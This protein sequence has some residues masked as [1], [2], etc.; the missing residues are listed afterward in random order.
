MAAPGGRTKRFA[1]TAVALAF[2]STAV[3]CATRMPLPEGM[4]RAAGPLGVPFV[5]QR[6]AECGPSS[7]A[8]VLEWS[9]ESVDME[10]LVDETWTPGRGGALAADLMGAARRH[11]RIAVPLRGLEELQRELAAGHPVLVM[12]NLGWGWL[13]FWHF[14]VAIGYDANPPPQVTL[15]S[16]K[17]AARRVPLRTFEYTWRRAERWGMVV[18]A[19][20]ELPASAEP[21]EMLEALAGLEGAGQLA[22]AERASA[23]ALRRW[24]DDAPLWVAH[25]NALLSQERLAE[26]EAAL[27]QA[28]AR[29]P[30]FAPAHNNLAHVLLRAGRAAEARPAALRALELG[31]PQPEFLDTLEAIERACA[32]SGCR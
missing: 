17:R 6:T 16:G 21:R 29:A 22:A 32:V 5:E 9:G 20:D 23:S 3:A 2:A 26:S 15:H 19:P 24:P 12:Q 7:L 11:G 28:V 31:G 4:P 18:T 27:R 13:P 14:A 1:A 25:A 10:R 8:M 30:T